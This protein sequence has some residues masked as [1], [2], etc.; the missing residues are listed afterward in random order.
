MLLGESDFAEAA[1]ALSIENEKT[2]RLAR[3]L[4]RKT[5][6]PVLQAV[7]TA[8][9]D[10]LERLRHDR[11]ARRKPRLEVI[12]AISRHFQ[13]LPDVDPREPDEILGYDAQGLP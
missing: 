8:L 7:T 1:V 13:S 12:E 9:E 3:E 4:A 5:G 6:E 10:R 2:E 11:P